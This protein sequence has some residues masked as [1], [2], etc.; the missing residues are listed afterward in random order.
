M[1]QG[2]VK[3]KRKKGLAKKSGESQ[4]RRRD[5]PY[6]QTAW[7]KYFTLACIACSHKN[8]D[9]MINALLMTKCNRNGKDLI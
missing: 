7:C 6:G 8:T 9:G 3:E 2:L 4:V 1:A 5:Y